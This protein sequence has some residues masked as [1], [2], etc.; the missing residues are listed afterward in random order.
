MLVPRLDP[1]VEV[2]A[3]EAIHGEEEVAREGDPAR[4]VRRRGGGELRDVG[5]ATGEDDEPEAPPGSRAESRRQRIL[6]QPGAVSGREHRQLGKHDEGR[7][8]DLAESAGARLPL[9]D[10]G[11]GP[12]GEEGPELLDG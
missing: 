10:P 2:A 9:V 1:P 12:A 4:S 8:D 3:V 11:G 5:I 6:P 7:E